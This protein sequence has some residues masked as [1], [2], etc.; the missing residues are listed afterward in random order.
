MILYLKLNI[1]SINCIVSSKKLTHPNERTAIWHEQFHLHIK[2]SEQETDGH[3]L[4]C[5]CTQIR[6]IHIL[7][8]LHGYQSIGP[9][10]RSWYPINTHQCRCKLTCHTMQ[11]I[12]LSIVMMFFQASNS[13]NKGKDQNRN[14]DQTPGTPVGWRLIIR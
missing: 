14:I 8:Q 1:G 10:C 13:S 12:H 2:H 5:S 3:L 6:Y 4:I 11:S 7:F 9:I